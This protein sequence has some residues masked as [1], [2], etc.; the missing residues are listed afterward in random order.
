MAGKMS[1]DRAI[2]AQEQT[3]IAE[4]CDRAAALYDADQRTE[5][6]ALGDEILTYA[7]NHRSVYY[8]A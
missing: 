8:P 5:A 6:K 2:Y 1:A 7:R 4:M 3:Q